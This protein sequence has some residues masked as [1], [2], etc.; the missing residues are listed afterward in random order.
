ML[1]YSEGCMGFKENI[2]S[3][4][5]ASFSVSNPSCPSIQTAKFCSQWRMFFTSCTTINLTMIKHLKTLSWFHSCSKFFA[6][7]IKILVILPLGSGFSWT[8]SR[9][10]F[11]SL[12]TA[13]VPNQ[14]TKECFPPTAANVLY[15]WC[16]S[17]WFIQNSWFS[18]DR[19][20]T[21]AAVAK[22]GW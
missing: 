20:S 17:C 16:Q 8:M 4:Y 11:P 2:F 6:H 15:P 1:N 3:C 21:C 5:S 12:L 10:V 7:C 22:N 13:D 9:T 18:F 19:T 14:L